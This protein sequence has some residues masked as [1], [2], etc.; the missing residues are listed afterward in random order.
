VTMADVKTKGAI[1]VWPTA[2]TSSTPP[3][4]LKERFPDMVPED[5][6]RAFPRPMQGRLPLLRIGWAVI[7]P[8]SPAPPPAVPAPPAAK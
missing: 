7:R 5:V 4:A 3:P 2:D 8:Q 6:P 1:I